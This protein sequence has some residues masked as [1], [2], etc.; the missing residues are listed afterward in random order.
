MRTMVHNH[1]KHCEELDRELDAELLSPVN[2]KLQEL[3]A[4]AGESADSPAD[5]GTEPAGGGP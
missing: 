1:A 3:Q 4:E 2:A 5:D